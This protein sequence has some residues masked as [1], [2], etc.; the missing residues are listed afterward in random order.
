M[1]DGFSQYDLKN[2]SLYAQD[3][4]THGRLT[5]QLGLRY[6]YNKDSAL[7]ATVVGN[8]LAGPWL[9][10]LNFG[11]ADPGVSFNNLS[12]R[13]GATYNLDGGGKTLLRANYAMYYGQVGNGGV[14]SIINPVS[15]TTLRYPWVDLNG[16]KFVQAN[17]VTLSAN[18]V[19]LVAGNWSSANPGNT[20]SANSVDPNLRNDKTQEVIVGFDREVGAGFAAGVSYI[21][22]KYSDFNWQDR[23]GITTADWIATTFTPPAASCP[24]ADGQRISAA[25]CP[26]VTF[27][28][29][30]FQQP[31]I[32]TLT[33][34]PDFNRVFNG[35]EL[36]ARKRM[37][38]HWLMNASY[39]YNSTVVNFGGF[40]GSQPNN[41]SATISEDPTARNFRDG[42]QYDY[43]TA[44]SGIGNV[45]VN[46][47]WLFKVSGLVNLPG[48]V[49]VSAFYNAR[50]GYPVEYTVQSPSRVN[51]ANQIDVLLAGVGETRLPNYQNVDFHVERPVKVGTCVSC[52]RWTSSTSTT[53]T[54]S[55][56]SAA[57]R[58]PRMPTRFRRS[59]RRVSP[60]SVSSSP[61]SRARLAQA[62]GPARFP[63]RGVQPRPFFCA[64]LSR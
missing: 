7:S 30:G 59:W 48:D 34:L 64:I 46:A 18:P 45:F 27:F 9:P 51:G 26:A 17:E 14:A 60:A 53:S 58:T 62:F 15:A 3:T 2:N 29:P 57:A 33:N 37:S 35:L 56:P 21:W 49:N 31:T 32:Q 6:D 11:G 13:V 39:A 20:V 40:P 4:Y 1:R 5:A 50:Q 8:P 63:G 25:N 61:G 41:S 43:L 44:G 12:P 47:K 24:G 38:H 10:G 16:D 42:F 23:P 28:Q 22:R 19:A 36:T 54:P 55:R 52:R